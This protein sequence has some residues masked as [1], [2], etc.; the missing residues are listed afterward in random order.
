MA[1]SGNRGAHLA[2]F[3]G[4][5]GDGMGGSCD[6]DAVQLRLAGGIKCDFPETKVRFLDARLASQRLEAERGV[7]WRG[8]N[9]HFRIGGCSIA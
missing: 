8:G 5:G 9:L 6:G 7:A 1:R 3:W 2:K 4:H